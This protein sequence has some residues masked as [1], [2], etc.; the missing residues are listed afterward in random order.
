MQESLQAACAPSK[1][2]KICVTRGHADLLHTRHPSKPF[3]HGSP[4]RFKHSI[5]VSAV[6]PLP[7]AHPLFPFTAGAP[8]TADFFNFKLRP[9]PFANNS[10]ASGKM[11]TTWPGK[12][13]P[14]PGALAA[15]QQL[16]TTMQGSSSSKVQDAVTILETAENVLLEELVDMGLTF[17]SW[18]VLCAVSKFAKGHPQFAAIS[19]GGL[20]WALLAQSLSVGQQVFPAAAVAAQATAAGKQQARQA[21]AAAASRLSEATAAHQLSQAT[22]TAGT[23][24][25]L[26]GVAAKRLAEAEATPSAEKRLKAPSPTPSSLPGPPQSVLPSGT[27]RAVNMSLLRSGS[28]PA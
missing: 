25:S 5:L 4:E 21:A 19:I 28:L 16:Q 9:E 13:V 24:T 12:V 17:R 15:I 22:T 2:H 26:G 23:G 18:S 10:L 27:R 1:W 3:G 8:T 7:S 6:Q 20:T 11:H 14:W